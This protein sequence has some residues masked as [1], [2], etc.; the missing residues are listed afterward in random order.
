MAEQ[1]EGYAKSSTRK[2]VR[3]R[4]SSSGINTIVTKGWLQFHEYSLQSH[5]LTMDIEYPKREGG[6][7][8]SMF[9]GIS[10]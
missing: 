6:S 5:Q 4:A 2:P 7:G 1:I 3:F 10:K 9:R 8:S